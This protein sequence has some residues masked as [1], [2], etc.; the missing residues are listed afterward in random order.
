MVRSDFG[1][2]FQ[3][4]VSSAAFQTEGV[5]DADGKGPSIWDTFAGKKGKIKYNHRA[6]T[7]CDFYNRYQTDIALIKEMHI[8]NF[9]FSLSWPRILPEG[10]G[11]FNAQGMDFYERLVDHCLAQ[12]ITPWITL[13]HW[14]LPQALQD[15]G[16]WTNRDVL[17]WLEAYAERVV[18]RLGDRVRHWMVL[19]EP[20]VFTGAGYFFGVH[21]P[22]LTGLRNFFPAA[23]HAA[24]AMGHIGRLLRAETKNAR[25]GSTF[26]C[27]SIHA[28]SSRRRDVDA[29]KRADALINRLF[30]EPILG[31]GYPT[32][33]LKA[34]AGIERYMMAGDE[35]QLP[36]DFDFIGIQN[37][38]REV[39][40]H[41]YFVPYLQARL[42]PAKKRH[43]P[44]VTEMGWEVYPEA[45]YEMIKQFNAY[46]NIPDIYITENGAA[47][48]DVVEGGAVHDRL[49]IQYLK[50][51]LAQVLR[52]KREG[53]NIHGYFIW[54]LT[55]NFEW[56]EGYHPRFG[57]VHVDFETQQRTMKDSGKWYGSFLAN[58]IFA[59]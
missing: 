21:A 37:Y 25:I 18:R 45:I 15:K 31:M 16:G 9:R 5:C 58:S 38:T 53:L 7:A 2:D 51:H 35:T 47:F 32:A 20:A 55:D 28:A 39:I 59:E 12:G 36:F 33:D 8:P 11:R 13:Y 4:G 19:N 24:L 23:H 56:A 1:H 46:P 52:A 6:H 57:L 10:T 42:V 54:T 34:L 43:V 14:D 48:A 22:G 44:L 40:R 3:W 29:A 49:R 26:S 41:S 17:G 30:I 50:D 27:S